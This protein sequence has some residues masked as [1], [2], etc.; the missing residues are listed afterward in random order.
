MYPME[1]IKDRPAAVLGNGP[2]LRG[3]DFK[4]ELSGFDTFGMNAAYRYWDTIGWYPT[5][6]S[7]LDRV[8]GAYHIDAIRRLIENAD[9]YGIQRFLL[10]ENIVDALNTLGHSSKVVN[11]DLLLAADYRWLRGYWYNTGS[12]TA[13]WAASIGY[14]D[15]ILL[16]VDANYTQ[17]VEGA[18]PVNEMVLKLAD[19]PTENPNYFFS[20]Y[21]RKGDIYHIPFRCHPDFPHEDQ[22]LG[23]HMIRPQI[24]LSGSVVVNANPASHVTAFPKCTFKDAQ[25][26]I[27]GVRVKHDTVLHLSATFI[28]EQGAFFNTN[29][30]AVALLPEQPGRLMD[31]GAYHGDGS[32]LFLQRGWQIFAFEADPRNGAILKQRLAKFEKAI[33]EEIAVSSVTG[34]KYPW[35]VFPSHPEWCTMGGHLPEHIYD[36]GTT[37]TTIRDYCRANQINNIDI[38]LVDIVGFELMALRGFPFEQ[39]QPSIIICAFDD[40]KSMPLYS[41]MHDLGSFLLSY[42][43]HVFMSEWHPMLTSED[44]PQ[45]RR[46]VSY[47]AEPMEP[48]AWG[49]F[50][51]FSKTPDYDNLAQIVLC[52]TEQRQFV[53]QPDVVPTIARKKPRYTI[54]Y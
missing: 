25:A 32:I 54:K 44:T 16:G 11:Y 50:F 13:A 24:K 52:N 51:A 43:Y 53:P 42:G 23:W 19:E 1:H 21:Q 6:Y 7:C 20:D 37:T 31:I 22:L 34:R 46:F 4:K 29:G 17:F 35:Y 47:P 5:Y 45:W 27:A 33:I 2:S 40:E 26:T 8:V 9:K 36:G 30:A 12:H 38:L 3:F 14:K 49:H 48:G 10:R 15:I 28:R 41:D 18:T 39:F